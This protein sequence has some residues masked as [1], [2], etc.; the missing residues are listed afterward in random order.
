M[1]QP[2]PPKIKKKIVKTGL[3]SQKIIFFS[4]PAPAPD[5]FYPQP[6]LAPGFYFKRLRLQTQGAKSTRLR[7]RLHNPE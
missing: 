5:F 7:L 6:T 1:A 2:T 4:A 3:G